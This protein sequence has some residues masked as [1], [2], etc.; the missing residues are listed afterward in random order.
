MTKICLF[1]KVDYVDPGQSDIGD[2]IL[3]LQTC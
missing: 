2:P 3:A 1:A